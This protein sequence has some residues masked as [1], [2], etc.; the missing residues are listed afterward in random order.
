MVESRPPCF[1]VP[2]KCMPRDEDGIVQPQENCRV[3]EHLRECLKTA[4]AASGGPER[5]RAAARGDGP[6]QREEPAGIVGAVLR[7]SASNRA[8]R[9]GEPT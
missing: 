7:W 9:R 8:A 5:V 3:C 2:E 6:V 1:G 4:I